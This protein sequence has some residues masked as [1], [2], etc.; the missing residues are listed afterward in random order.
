MATTIGTRDPMGV[1]TTRGSGIWTTIGYTKGESLPRHSLNI[2]LVLTLDASPYA[3]FS[4][5]VSKF[6]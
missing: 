1:P 3:C 2:S 4:K 6:L 5:H